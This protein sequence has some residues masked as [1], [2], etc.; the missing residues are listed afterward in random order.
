MIS[1]LLSL[2]YANLRASWRKYI[3]TGLGIAVAAF[4][5][6][7]VLLLNTIISATYMAHYGNQVRNSD[8]VV[9]TNISGQAKE[10]SSGALSVEEVEDILDIEFIYRMPLTEYRMTFFIALGIAISASWVLFRTSFKSL[11]SSGTSRRLSLCRFY[12]AY[13]KLLYYTKYLIEHIPIHIYYL[14]IHS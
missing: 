4:F 12:A 2:I 13:K 1:S 11:T 7:A 10:N 6:S 8:A 3:L 5:L 14:H 9:A